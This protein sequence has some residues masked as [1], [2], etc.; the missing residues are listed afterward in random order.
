[1]LNSATYFWEKS[2]FKK[3]LLYQ[4]NQFSL[5]LFVD[6]EEIF[7]NENKSYLIIFHKSMMLSNEEIIISNMIINIT[8][9]LK[10]LNS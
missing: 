2:I 3:H 7:N 6:M 1:M 8:E 9:T 5:S 10:E 4:N